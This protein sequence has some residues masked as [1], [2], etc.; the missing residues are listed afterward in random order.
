M[1]EFL[2]ILK[3]V[4]LPVFMIMGIGFFLQRKFDL[5][6]QTLA[7]LNIYFLVPG[8]I[9]VKLY[10][11]TFSGQLLLQILVFFILLIVILYIIATI[12]TRLIGFDKGKATTFS[13]SILFFNSG[14]YGVPVN[15]LV[16]KSDPLAM[17]I[18]VIILTF[19]NILLFSYGIFSLQSIQIGKLRALLSYFKMP[20]LY[21]MLAGILLNITEVSIPSFVWVPANYIADAM[22]AMALLTLGAQVAQLRLSAVLPTVYVSLALRLVL[23]PLVALGIIFLL[24]MDGLVAQALFIASAMPTAVNSS[25][26]AQEYNNH[27]TFAAQ[28]VLFSTV[29]STITVTAVIYFSRLL[30]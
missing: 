26:I 6:L 8:F 27:P 12:T 7:R 18:Q 23:G 29:F 22:V 28:I 14:N 16:F 30:F 25:V 17:S 13:N 24:Q 11:T 15:D 3:D 4:I 19:Q 2:I 10:D 21:A 5:D 20:V 1:E 9:F